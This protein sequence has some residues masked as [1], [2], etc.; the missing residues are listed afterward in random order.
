MPK[1]S[2][3]ELKEAFDE[4]DADKSGALTYEDLKTLV[5]KFGI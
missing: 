2:P 3:E 1:P 4:L 5:T